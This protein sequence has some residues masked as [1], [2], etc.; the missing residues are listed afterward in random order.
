MTGTFAERKKGD[1]ALVYEWTVQTGSLSSNGTFEYYAS[2]PLFE[3][4]LK[5]VAP[6][7]FS[8]YEYE[9]YLENKSKNK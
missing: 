2:I 7:L 1:N 5:G 3:N 9:L 6:F 4:D 8:S